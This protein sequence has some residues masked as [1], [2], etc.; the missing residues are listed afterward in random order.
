MVTHT[1]FETLCFYAHGKHSS[2][3]THPKEWQSFKKL[4]LLGVHHGKLNE[5]ANY[6]AIT[7]RPNKEFCE[8]AHKDCKI[9][10]W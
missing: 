10:P 3:S 8:S 4:L 1:L 5:H 7:T 9:A 6:K 2:S